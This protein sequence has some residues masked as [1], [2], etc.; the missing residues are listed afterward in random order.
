LAR[1]ERRLDQRQIEDIALCMAAAEAVNDLSL[2]PQNVCEATPRGAAVAAIHDKTSRPG[3]V[4][5]KHS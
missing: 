3:D 1:P 5:E 2:M 4:Y